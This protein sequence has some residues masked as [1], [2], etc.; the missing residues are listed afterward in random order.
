MEKEKLVNTILIVTILFLVL[1]F[2]AHLRLLSTETTSQELCRMSIIE[3]WTGH[4]FHWYNPVGRFKHP[5]FSGCK[6]YFFT[7]NHKGIKDNQGT[8]LVDFSDSKYKHNDKAIKN[9]ILHFLS[10]QMAVC[11]STFSMRGTFDFNKVSP[12]AFGTNGI[13]CYTC[14]D[15]QINELP[16][17]NISYSEL[18]NYMKNNKLNITEEDNKIKERSYYDFIYGDRADEL[19]HFQVSLWNTIKSDFHSVTDLREILRSSPPPGL[20]AQAR[21]L[22]TL[23]DSV[24]P[25][26][27]IQE[28]NIKEPSSYTKSLGKAYN[29]SGTK[30]FFSCDSGILYKSGVSKTEPVST[31]SNSPY[32]YAPLN[33]VLFCSNNNVTEIN[34]QIFCS[35]NNLYNCTK[36]GSKIIKNCQNGCEFSQCLSKPQV[37]TGSTSK[38]N[39]SEGNYYVSFY[40]VGKPISYE[41]PVPFVILANADTM[42]TTCTWLSLK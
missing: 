34:N 27:T 11:W 6:T 41:R 19:K 35:G 25:Q 36:S 4:S 32:C 13:M 30:T 23:R 21:I 12:R 9:A 37:S 40:L 16:C 2:I 22:A 17:G 7:I 8:L 29:P 14:A 18:L 38:L 42:F 39:I 24:I 10:D 3:A 20:I 26:A 31:S 1:A 28:H 5:G 33:K 15:V